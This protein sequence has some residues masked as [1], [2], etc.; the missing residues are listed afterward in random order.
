MS[1][2]KS[3][4]GSSQIQLAISHHSRQFEIGLK[5]GGTHLCHKDDFI[6]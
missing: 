4:A 6:V 1:I 3:Q 5:L 2:Q